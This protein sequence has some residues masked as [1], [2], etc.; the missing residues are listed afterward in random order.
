MDSVKPLKIK[1]KVQRPLLNVKPKAL[2]KSTEDIKKSAKGVYTITFGDVAENG[3]GMERIG[4]LHSRGISVIELKDTA[5]KFEELGFSTELVDL[6]KVMD[7]KLFND[8]LQQL[9]KSRGKK[10]PERNEAAILIVRN[11]V[12]ALLGNDKAADLLKEEQQHISYDTMKIMYGRQVNSKARHNVCFDNYDQDIDLD[13][14]KGTVVDFKHLPHLSKFKGELGDF[15]PLLKEVNLRAEGN[16]YYQSSCGIGKHGD[17][18]RRIVA[19]IRLGESMGL[20]YYWYFWHKQVG[21]E[22][23]LVLNHGDIYIM[24]DKAVGFDSGSPSK[25]TLRHSA[26]VFKR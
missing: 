2:I 22:I 21:P 15:I 6:T 14:M 3:T 4:S 18:E 19:A 8:Q 11:G 24:S 9:I 5:L 1:I 13:H 26:G 7:D 23:N 12:N 25:L 16:Y 17:K 10:V 20:N